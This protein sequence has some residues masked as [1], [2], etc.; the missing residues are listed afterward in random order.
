MSVSTTADP[1][2]RSGFRYP[3]LVRFV[4]REN[5]TLLSPA[6]EHAVMYVNIEARDVP[7]RPLASP[8]FDELVLQIFCF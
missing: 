7:C 6:F 4:N 1:N 3:P 8:C 2:I 5:G